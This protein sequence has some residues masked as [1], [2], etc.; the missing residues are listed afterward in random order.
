[1][2][3]IGGPLWE[4]WPNWQFSKQW[5]NWYYDFSNPRAGIQFLWLLELI[6]LNLCF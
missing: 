4:N 3:M 5:V 6:I 2:N 1:M